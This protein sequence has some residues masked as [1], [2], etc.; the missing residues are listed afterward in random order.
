MVTIN[1]NHQIET[2]WDIDGLEFPYNVVAKALSDLVKSNA[3]TDV[4]FGDQALIGAQK[5][6]QLLEDT[7]TVTWDHFYCKLPGSI[8]VNSKEESID[9]RKAPIRDAR[10]VFQRSM[11]ELTAE[12]G[13]TVLELIE[14][15]SLYRGDEHKASIQEFLRYK[16]QYAALAPEAKGNWCWANAMNNR[17]SKIRNTALGTLLVNLSEG[18]DLDTAVR[19]FEAVM[20]PS[21]YKRPKALVTAKMIADAEKTIVELGY[22]ESLARRHAVPEDITV[23][24]VIFVNRDA[25]KTL[26]Q[27]SA[28]DMLKDDV[29]VATTDKTLARVEEIGIDDF[30]TN[31][32]PKVNDIEL[33]VESRHMRSLMS[34]VAPVNQS[35]PCM[36]KWNNNFSWSYTG[37]VADSHMKENVKAAGG[38]VDGV[39][40]FSIQWNEAG[41]NRNDF[42][43]HCKEPDGNHIGFQNKRG[44][45]SGGE[46]DVDI[47]HPDKSQTAVENITWPST[48]RMKDG[49]YTFYVNNWSHRGGSSGF[50]AEIEFEGQVYQFNHTRDITQGNNVVVA[51]VKFSKKDGFSIVE[52]MDSTVATREVWG[53]KT[54]Q[55]VKVS[56]MMFSPNFWDGQQGIGNKHYMFILDGCKNDAAPRGYYNEFL[57]A[58][59]DKHKRVFEVLGSKMRVEP[60]DRQ[61]SGVGFSTT[62]RN[63][64]VAKV[65]GSFSRTLKINF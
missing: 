39:L 6:V 34:L 57:N 33:L 43:A 13:Q 14:Q 26:K 58:S 5:T 37:D 59:L 52:S 56:M 38:K 40:R 22:E 41:D 15:G 28:L 12:A 2:I 54:Q 44:H 49:V 9:A 17:V 60:S 63:S 25:R 18:M 10:N 42:D 47:I 64:I 32:V 4:F 8:V 62:V 7:T 21:N 23:N 51:K 50:R 31:I 11:E 19:K 55:F 46:L 24:N 1:A 36:L 65:S 3:V 45:A 29:A 16:A 20:A 61:L 35:A 48:S 30:I 27:T 53:I